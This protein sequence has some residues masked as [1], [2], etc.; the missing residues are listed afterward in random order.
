MSEYEN[1]INT[2]I[3]E[4]DKSEQNKQWTKLDDLIWYQSWLSDDEIQ[5]EL[6][7]ATQQEQYEVIK[8]YDLAQDVLYISHKRG[9]INFNERY[10]AEHFLA[11]CYMLSTS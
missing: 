7:I 2:A 3:K 6:N 5:R 1:Q 11:F 8:Y 9:K 10:L 4:I